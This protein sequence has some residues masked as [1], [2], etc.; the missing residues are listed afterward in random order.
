M[1]LNSSGK[2]KSL[3]LPNATRLVEQKRGRILQRR[4]A[5]VLR[6]WHGRG[7]FSSAVQGTSNARPAPQ[8]TFRQYARIVAA[9]NGEKVIYKNGK[10]RLASRRDK[11]AHHARIRTGVGDSGDVFADS[12]SQF[13][14]FANE[15]I[16]DAG[17]KDRIKRNHFKE[18]L[19][20]YGV[21]AYIFKSTLGEKEIGDFL[22]KGKSQF[23]LRDAV[24]IMVHNYSS[25]IDF[26]AKSHEDLIKTLRYNKINALKRI[27]N[28]DFPAMGRYNPE[29][30]EINIL[31]DVISTN[32]LIHEVH[33]AYSSPEFCE[34]YGTAIDEGVTENLALKSYFH[35]RK[36][37]YAGESHANPGARYAQRKFREGF[38]WAISGYKKEVAVIRELSRQLGPEGEHLVKRAYFKGRTGMDELEA[39]FEKK[40]GKGSFARFLEIVH[41][42][43]GDPDLSR[44]NYKR[45]IRF[46]RTPAGAASAH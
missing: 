33:H 31:V 5:P 3:N 22:S 36:A 35:A 9:E 14:S 39:E 11:I 27:R 38:D 12:K 1:P 10:W 40:Y 2:V 15:A 37:R 8:V 43:P 44:K 19:E 45:A 7:A 6:N 25:Y 17:K 16:T 34:E 4:M 46:L 23:S 41:T 18:S 24:N 13:M 21:D 42:T 30:R 26:I 32:T 29:T 28:L 20:H